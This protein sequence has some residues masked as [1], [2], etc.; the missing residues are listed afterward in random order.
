[1]FYVHTLV[2]H[3][4]Y[5]SFNSSFLCSQL[6]TFPTFSA[7]L[8]YPHCTPLFKPVDNFFFHLPML[9]FVQNFTNSPTQLSIKIDFSYSS[10]SPQLLPNLTPQVRKPIGS[11][12]SFLLSL[13]IWDKD[14]SPNTKALDVTLK[15]YNQPPSIVLGEDTVTAP[16]TAHLLDT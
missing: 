11:G 4:L 3:Y 16:C 1:M 9:K 8:Q 14:T 15:L 2:N 6:K 5:F 10:P 7:P 13:T 12:S